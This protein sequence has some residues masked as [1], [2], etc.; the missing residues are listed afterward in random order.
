MQGKTSGRQT[1]FL[2]FLD[3]FF[4][5][6]RWSCRGGFRANPCEEITLDVD[7]SDAIQT[8]KQKL[9]D[10]DEKFPSDQQRLI[11]DGKQ[12]ED[13]RTLADYK[14]QKEST[15]HL[16]LRL[17]GNSIAGETITLDVDSLDTIKTVK[18]KLSKV[19]YSYFSIDQTGLVFNKAKLEDRWSVYHLGI[20]AS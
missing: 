5:H 6:H 8:V 20:S 4:R 3:S 12:L 15:L 16:V 18:Q 10:K 14:I 9:H 19:K 7:S 11:F 17:G 13:G 2:H 1:D